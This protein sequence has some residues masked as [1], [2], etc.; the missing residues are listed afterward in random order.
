MA[1]PAAPVVAEA[2]PANLAASN[3]LLG[4]LCTGATPSPSPTP[5]P[6]ASPSTASSCLLGLI[7]CGTT[8]GTSGPCVL[9][10]L[11]CG[12]NVISQPTP[13]VVGLLC[14]PPSQ[15]PCVGGAV[16]CPGTILGPG[17]P[18][19]TG[20]GSGGP[21]GGGSRGSG[22]PVTTQGLGTTNVAVALGVPPG[23]GLIPPIVG[24][25][26]VG[27][28]PN[29]DGF[30]ELLSLSIRDGLSPGGSQ[31]WPALAMLQAVLL[32]VIVGAFAARR[33]LEASKL[34]KG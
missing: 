10:I 33:V 28:T 6:A 17:N 25:S 15:S 24:Q 26:A 21:S 29:P 3:C 16:L 22:G 31:L 7:G 12:G 11:L 14:P 20:G 19:P 4:L 23:V 5:S 8:P 9:N 30:S 34:P 2:A 27:N 1:A 18:P 32:L 13:C